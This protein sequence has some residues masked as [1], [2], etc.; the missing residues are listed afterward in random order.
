[1]KSI[2]LLTLGLLLAVSTYAQT[3]KMYHVPNESDIRKSIPM[4]DRYQFEN[5][6]KGTVHFRNGTK[7]QAQLNYSFFHSE[8]QFID[9]RKDTLL[10][11]DNSFVIQIT[12]DTLVYYYLRKEGHIQQIGGFDKIRLGRKQNL[13]VM[14]TEYTSGYEGKSSTSAISSYSTYLDKG[15]Q[16]QKLNPATNIMMR[17]GNIYFWMDQN[18]RFSFATKANLYK[19]FPKHKREL[20]SYFKENEISFTDEN[21]MIKLLDFCKSL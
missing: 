1:M 12:I 17:R 7:S 3:K 2:L 15:G 5:F 16:M 10:L 9:P 18:D 11:A 6:K 14:G 4:K 8:I 13:V 20:S 19:L 21:D